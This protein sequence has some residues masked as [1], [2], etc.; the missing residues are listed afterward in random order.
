[1]FY[2]NNQV[3]CME[4]KQEIELISNYASR[5]CRQSIGM[6]LKKYLPLIKK[7]AWRRKASRFEQAELIN[8]GVIGFCKAV[9]CFDGDNYEGS[10]GLYA[11]HFIKR[12]ISDFI[13]ENERTVKNPISRDQRR[14]LSNIRKLT[15]SLGVMNHD[16]CKAIADSENVTV[17]DVRMIER[18][19]TGRDVTLS[20]LNSHGFYGE[21]DEWV[22]WEQLYSSDSADDLVILNEREAMTLSLNNAVALLDERETIIITSRWLGAKKETMKSISERLC[23]S[24]ERVRQLEQRATEK[25]KINCASWMRKN[26][27]K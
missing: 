26:E 8:E 13:I 18:Y 17:S 3:A 19:L 22:D 6:L 20:V 12:E 5:K 4:R 10:L 15:N 7:E 21:T 9:N 24:I 1:M 27:V 2:K 16:E 23:I 14:L 25:L 11:A